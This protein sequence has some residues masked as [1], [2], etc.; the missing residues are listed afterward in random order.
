MQ[1]DR[2]PTV[3]AA[4]DVRMNSEL[5]RS[6]RLSKKLRVGD[7]QVMVVSRKTHVRGDVHGRRHCNLYAL[8]DYSAFDANDEHRPAT[9]ATA[10]NVC[11]L[12]TQ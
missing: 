4:N 5:Q 1:H 2:T 11:H 8:T 3:C 9:D 7:E 10:T 12:L 6:S